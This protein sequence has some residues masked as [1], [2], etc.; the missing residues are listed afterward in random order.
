M[1]VLQRVPARQFRP[2]T[3]RIIIAERFRTDALK[4]ERGGGVISR[5]GLAA[6]TAQLGDF[7][8]IAAFAY[9]GEEERKAAWKLNLVFVDKN[10]RFKGTRGYV[11]SQS[12]S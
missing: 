1:N 12:W 8:I 6:L 3:E 11:H 5:N 10:N 9:V 4:G 2:A 7:V